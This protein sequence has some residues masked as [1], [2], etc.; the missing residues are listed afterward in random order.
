M[1][2]GSR[3][4]SQRGFTYITMMT[5]VA[6]LGIGL[7]ALGPM[8]ADDAQR[9][10]EQELL[11]VGALYASAIAAYRE[12][13]PG[14]LKRYPP[15]LESLVLDTRFVGTRRHLR[16]LYADP[17]LPSRPW[18]LLRDADGGV[19]GVFSEDDRVPL[20]RASLDVGV[21]RLPAA[22]RYADWKFMPKDAP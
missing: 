8:W 18:G 11:R 6:L 19:R 15:N 3:I 7:A 20:L 16:K 5:V 21:R 12:V 17:L 2:T 22:Q 13:S 10:R 9:Q 14:S 4:A 1:Q